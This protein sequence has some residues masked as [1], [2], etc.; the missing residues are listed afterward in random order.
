MIY[1]LDKGE[2]A[3]AGNY[4][5]LMAKNGIFYDVVTLQESNK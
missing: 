5:N 3:E 2:L 1:V 4:R